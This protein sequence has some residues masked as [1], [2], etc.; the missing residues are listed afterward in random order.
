MNRDTRAAL[1]VITT[2]ATQIILLRI[3][4]TAAL[5]A[6]VG[7]VIIAVTLGRNR[8]RQ[9]L[10]TVRGL[11]VILTAVLLTRLVVEFSLSTFQGW[12]I[13]TARLLSAVMI[14]L[15]ALG[16]VGSDGIVRG[17]RFLLIPVPGVFRRP[18]LDLVGSTLYVLPVVRRRFIAS[19][20]AAR[21]RLA[22]SGRKG[23][24]R[25]VFIVRSVLVSIAAIPRQRAEAMVVRGLLRDHESIPR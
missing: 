10:R 8:P 19:T 25:A 12:A 23:P 2:V 13:Y 20:S 4:G 3:G 11:L 21:I 14:A 16:L 22:A 6:L 5:I 7:S 24:S 17:L 18:I 9:L 1:V 15:T